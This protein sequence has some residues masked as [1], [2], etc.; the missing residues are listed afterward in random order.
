[1]W[2]YIVKNNRP[3]TRVFGDKNCNCFIESMQA[4]NWQMSMVIKI[5]NV[6]LKVCKQKIAKRLKDRPWI[7][8]RLKWSIKK[9]HRLYRNT[10]Y[11]KCPHMISK[12]KKYKAILSNCLKVAEQNYYCQ[13]FDCINSSTSTGDTCKYDDVMTYE[14][15]S[16]TSTL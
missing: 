11:N 10:L 1:M 9:S 15:F 5:E 7:T 2:K 6:L 13:L 14:F 4:E 12:Y 3:L 8:A 16:I